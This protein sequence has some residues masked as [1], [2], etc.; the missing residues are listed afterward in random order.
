MIQNLKNSKSKYNSSTQKLQVDNLEKE[1]FQLRVSKQTIETEL[2][3][4]QNTILDQKF[5]MQVKESDNFQIMFQKYIM[6]ANLANWKLMLIKVKAIFNICK[7]KTA[8]DF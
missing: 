7:N 5:I 2:Q 6:I 8:S 4:L 1:N 3:K